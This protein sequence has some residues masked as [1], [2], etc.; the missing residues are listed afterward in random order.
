MQREHVVLIVEPVVDR[1]SE[2]RLL[3]VGLGVSEIVDFTFRG[4]P[5]MRMRPGRPRAKP[6]KGQACR[7]G[8]AER[9]N[10]TIDHRPRSAVLFG[11]ATIA[12][13]PAKSRQGPHAVPRYRHE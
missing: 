3:A 10:E 11:C 1:I 6:R 13:T 9:L 2:R 8:K 4:D 5:N 7:E 12:G